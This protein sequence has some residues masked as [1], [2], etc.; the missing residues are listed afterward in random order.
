MDAPS[1]IPSRLT[2]TLS[3]KDQIVAHALKEQLQQP[4]E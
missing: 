3:G 4:L 2:D 1:A